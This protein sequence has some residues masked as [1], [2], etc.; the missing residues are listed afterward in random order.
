MAVRKVC[1]TTSSAAAKPASISPRLSSVSLA[2]LLGRSSLPAKVP[3]E[4]PSSTGGAPARACL[5][6]DHRL[7]DVVLHLDRRQG[8]LGERG[9]QGGD[10]RHRLPVEDGL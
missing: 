6:V 10:G 4:T 5:A 9:G 2:T 3:V 8:L 7:V 1:S